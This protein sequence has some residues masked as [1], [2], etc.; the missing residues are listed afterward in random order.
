[1]VKQ[2]IFNLFV[3]LTILPACSVALSSNIVHAAFSLLFCLF[4]IAGLYAL[5]GAD[6]I[7]VVQVVIYIGGILVLIIFAVMM[8]QGGKLPALSI[9]L[10]GRL[11]ALALAAALLCLLIVAV[12]EVSWN[13]AALLPESQPTTADLGNL[14]LSRYLVPFELASLLLLAVLVGAVLIVRRSVR[15]Q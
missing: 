15:G 2:I 5:L 6:F 3:L 13:L 10:P 12:L 1:M 11:T 8:T 4:G 9:R 7:A 14:L